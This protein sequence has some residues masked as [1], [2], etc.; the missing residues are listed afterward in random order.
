MSATEEAPRPHKGRSMQEI[1]A[2]VAGDLHRWDE[3]GELWNDLTESEQRHLIDIA[4]AL[5][6]VKR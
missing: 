1:R 3:L 5:L 2:I 4:R 6:A